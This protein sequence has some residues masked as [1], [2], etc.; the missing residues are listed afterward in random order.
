MSEWRGCGDL[1]LSG[2]KTPGGPGVDVFLAFY[3]Y[4]PTVMIADTLGDRQAQP[5]SRVSLPR[6]PR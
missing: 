4:G 2:R 3:L 1:C 5:A 6:K